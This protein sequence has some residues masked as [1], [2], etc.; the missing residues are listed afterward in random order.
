[1]TPVLKLLGAIALLL[2]ALFVGYAVCAVGP[3]NI[4]Q[5]AAGVDVAVAAKP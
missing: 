4:A 3:G 1:M 2:A 5:M